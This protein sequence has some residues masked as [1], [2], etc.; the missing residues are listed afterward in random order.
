MTKALV[1]HGLISFTRTDKATDREYEDRA[2]RGMTVDIPNRAE[3]D[4]L[5]ELGA[6]VPP[7]HELDLPGRLGAL[8]DTAT[9]EE[10]LN[11]ALAAKPSEVEAEARRRPILAERLKAAA[12]ETKRRLEA[13]NERMGGF[14]DA[15]ERGAEKG[16][17]DAAA[18]R[19]AAA[20]TGAPDPATPGPTAGA[21]APTTG[22]DP[23]AVREGGAAGDAGDETGTGEVATDEYYDGIV[24]GNAREVA[25]FVAEN[26]DHY[27]GVL[28]AENRRAALK[29]EQPRQTVVK[30][31][32]VA[33]QHQG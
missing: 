10:I 22:G 1:R 15:A 25:D 12:D 19:E 20:A 16:L 9:D 27:E 32:E 7:D 33:A 11:W 2:F 26:P 4:R 3:Y 6:I 5:I 21:V 17:K 23:S 24:S 29:S 18:A 31:C 28:E 30:A 8:P 14:I 13:Y